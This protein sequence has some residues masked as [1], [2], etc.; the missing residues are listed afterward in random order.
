MNAFTFFVVCHRCSQEPKKSRRRHAGAASSAAAEPGPQVQDGIEERDGAVAQEARRIRGREEDDTTVGLA[1]AARCLG[2]TDSSPSIWEDGAV[3]GLA[4]AAQCLS[5]T[6]SPPGIWEDGAVV[7]LG[8]WRW[9]LSA[10]VSLTRR[11][12]SG[13]SGGR[14]SGGP[15]SGGSVNRP[16]S[17]WRLGLGLGKDKESD[18]RVGMTGGEI[19]IY[20]NYTGL[21]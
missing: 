9:R 16:G 3:A 13:R 2:V 1:V 8:A 15:D 14:H 12:V 11:L 18:L 17:R 4:G 19:S 10:S 7:G 6:D 5:V 20:I 21:G